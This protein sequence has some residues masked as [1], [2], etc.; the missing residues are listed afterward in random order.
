MIPQPQA[1]L[2]DDFVRSTAA[3]WDGF[4]YA[5][6]GILASAINPPANYTP[7]DAPEV[8]STYH[9]VAYNQGTR[10]I[11]NNPSQLP[12]ELPPAMQQHIRDCLSLG[13]LWVQVGRPEEDE[14]AFFIMLSANYAKAAYIYRNNW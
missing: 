11:P 8:G 1:Y 9:V 3:Q 13:M 6:C 4:Y 12:V 14:E 7:Q 2:E 5:P 10:E